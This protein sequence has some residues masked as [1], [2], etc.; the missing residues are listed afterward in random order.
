VGRDGG[1]YREVMVKTILPDVA[2]V[3]LD[4]SGSIAGPSMGLH[5][6]V[7]C[8]VLYVVSNVPF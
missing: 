6:W 1:R 7:F 2:F 8:R 4:E 3:E 5:W